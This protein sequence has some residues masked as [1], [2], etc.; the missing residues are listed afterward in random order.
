[1]QQFHPLF[2]KNEFL[3][4]FYNSAFSDDEN[5]ILLIP[6]L[7]KLTKRDI[8]LSRRVFQIIFNASDFSSESF[9]TTFA[10]NVLVKAFHQL[11]D[12][13]KN[14]IEQTKKNFQVYLI[15]LKKLP[16]DFAVQLIK[17]C[18]NQFLE[19]AT[20]HLYNSNNNSNS[21]SNNNNDNNNN[22]NNSNTA[23]VQ[24]LFLKVINVG[25]EE[26]IW[27]TLAQVTRQ[28]SEEVNSASILS[29]R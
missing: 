8:S 16:V 2:L 15:V 4:T 14:D 21:N 23:L 28:V 22:D 12:S 6:A 19:A 18:V 25:P 20:A 1:M 27:T 5:V 24:E 11:F 26:I 17:D 9:Y 3:N 13:A 29:V 7:V 10:K